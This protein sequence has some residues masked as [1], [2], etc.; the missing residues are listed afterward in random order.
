[1]SSE[2]HQKRKWHQI[3]HRADFYFSDEKNRMA[4][5]TPRIATGI[6]VTAYKVPYPTQSGSLSVMP[7][8]FSSGSLPTGGLAWPGRQP[9]AVAS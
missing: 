5:V 3:D 6:N 7:V 9:G 4:T 2:E 1:M 8:G